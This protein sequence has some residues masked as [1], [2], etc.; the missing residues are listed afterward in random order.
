MRALAVALAGAGDR[1]MIW[2]GCRVA[3]KSG[4]EAIAQL[5]RGTCEKILKKF[6]G[7]ILPDTL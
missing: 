1:C 2:S 7:R 5:P 6:S 4:F 3:Q